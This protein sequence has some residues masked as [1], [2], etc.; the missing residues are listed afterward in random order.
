[1]KYD[2]PSSYWD[3]DGFLLGLSTVKVDGDFA[4]GIDTTAAG[5]VTL[6]LHFDT[7]SLPVKRLIHV[8]GIADSVFTLQKDASLVRY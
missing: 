7:H 3:T 2:D 1:M 8:F 4:S 5:S 6:N